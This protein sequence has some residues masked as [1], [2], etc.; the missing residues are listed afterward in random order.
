MKK[1]L[2]LALAVLVTLTLCACG[3]LSGQKDNVTFYYQRANFA[4]RGDDGVIAPEERE[5]AGYRDNLPYLM[6][7][8]FHGPLDDSLV[9]PFPGGIAVVDIRTEDTTMVITLNSVF[10]QL[11]DLE[12]SIAS[13]CLAKTCFGLSDVQEVRIESL[14]TTSGENV[15]IL[16][17]RDNHLLEDSVPTGTAP[18]EK[19]D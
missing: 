9:S 10:T 19:S 5:L 16:I 15:S 8:Y 1:Q 13:I 2:A 4:Y 11:K 3:F 17:T 12:L 18:T 6:T 14:S 7:L